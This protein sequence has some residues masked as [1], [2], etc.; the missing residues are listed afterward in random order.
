MG[1]SDEQ[2]LQLP[3]RPGTMGNLAATHIEQYHLLESL[4]AQDPEPHIA[5][6]ALESRQRRLL[7]HLRAWNFDAAKAAHS[8]HAHSAAWCK[9]GMDN[10]TEKDE[11][12]ESETMFICGEDLWGRPT[13]IAR[14]SVF[15]P[16]D[17]EESIQTAHRCAYTL[18][19]AI[20]SMRPGI[21]QFVVLYDVKGVTHRNVDK[22]FVREV[23]ESQGPL[24]PDRCAAI[25]CINV[26]WTMLV[27]WRAIS[28][29]LPNT[30]KQK[31]KLYGSN[32]L[33]CILA[34]FFP[35]N[36]PYVQYLLKLQRLPAS[37]ADSV[38]LP[39]RSVCV[40]RWQQALELD[41]NLDIRGKM[42]VTSTAS[43]RVSRPECGSWL[44]CFCFARP[45]VEERTVPVMQ[46]PLKSTSEPGDQ[47]V[48]KAPDPGTTTRDADIPKGFM[49]SARQVFKSCKC[50][51]RQRQEHAGSSFLARVGF[52][53]NFL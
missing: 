2:P 11:M 17:A 24:F 49:A 44:S 20:S 48:M 53:V 34:D 13:I 47:L 22:V 9:Y 19:R 33:P 14:P 1:C 31:V 32:D 10:F 23:V 51:C 37:D 12:N 45:K 43:Q 25:I 7:R 52:H 16:V 27:F 8:I 26:H 18:Q 4:L 30:T 29:L 21:E 39:P 6:H 28:V 50:H 15:F 40:P 42:C 36:H 46:T 41:N 35:K 38:Q 3:A 5:A